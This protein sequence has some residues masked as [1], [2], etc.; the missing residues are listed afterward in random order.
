MR[1]A[2]ASLL[3]LGAAGLLNGCVAVVIPIAAA[4]VIGKTQLDAKKRAKRAEVTMIG[5]ADR[6]R[7]VEI[8]SETDTGQRD[9]AAVV[10]DPPAA[11]LNTAGGLTVTE[12]LA[13]SN[14]RHSYFKFAQYSLGQAA[15]HAAGLTPR[16]AVLVENVSLAFPKTIDCGNKPLAVIIDL[17]AAPA[18]TPDTP[19]SAS[20]SGLAELL[21][22]MREGGIRIAWISGESEGAVQP[23][24]A[25]LQNGPSPILKPSDLVSFAE[26]KGLRKQ[27][28]RWAIANNHCVIAVAGDR[29]ADFDELY[30]YIRQPDYAIRLDAM[31]DR[32]WFELPAPTAQTAPEDAAP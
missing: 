19:A 24:V 16:S 13:I 9:I 22:L 32:G 30:D 15:K 6:T 2:V 11:V 28:R 8:T 26:R 4:G 7:A 1:R 27:E 10:P 18:V 20:T 3:L 14:I 23:V 12:R 21:E 29:R 17:D 5:V 31:W 25:A